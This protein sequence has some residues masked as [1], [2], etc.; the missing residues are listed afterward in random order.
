MREL[1]AA[2]VSL[3]LVDVLACGGVL[4]PIALNP[5]ETFLEIPLLGRRYR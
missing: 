2:A 5:S 4:L 3:L 1:A